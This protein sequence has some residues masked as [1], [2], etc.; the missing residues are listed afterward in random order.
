MA[1][2]S[3]AP[4]P[5]ATPPAAAPPAAAAPP[6][7]PI[8]IVN[9]DLSFARYPVVVGHFLGDSIAGAEAQLDFA[10]EA[11]LKKRYALGIYP[12]TVGTAMVVPPPHGSGTTGVVVGLGDIGA[13]SPGMIRGALI[14]GLLELALSSA[15]P[16]GASGVSLIQLGTRAGTVSITD[17]V[18]ASLA[19]LAE[20]QRRLAEQ[21]LQP[22]TE[23]DFIALFEDDAHKLWHTLRRFIDSPHYRDLFSLEREVSYAAGAQ[24]RLMRMEDPDVWRAIQV[25]SADTG[26]GDMGFRFVAVGEQARAD[27]FLVGANKSFVQEF[28][29]TA[30][31]RKLNAAPTRALF[32]LIWPAE[33]KQTSQDDRN[34]RLIL[35]EAAAALPFELMDDRA[36]PP[37]GAATDAAGPPAVRRGMLRQ[38]IQSRFARLQTSP[39]GGE[40]AL[41]IG[42]PR[43][44]AP[45]ADFAPLPGARA[46]AEMVADAL[47]AQ[48][49][50]VVRLIGDAV[51]P[52]EVV[53]QVLQGGWTILHVSAHG[54]Y[55]YPF[56]S[57]R[58]VA[59]AAGWDGDWTHYT[60]PRYTGVVLGDR[61]TLSP[62]IL[63][64][65]PDPPVLAFINC[66]SLASID[67][68][69]EA[70][71]RA[72]ARPEFAASFAA[73]L[74]ALGSRA[75]I[76]AGW[77]VSDQGALVFARSVYR[78]LLA[79]N[80]GFGEAVRVARGDVYDNDPDDATWGAYQ[81]YG[82]PDWRP[83]PDNEVR[84]KVLPAPCFAS[85]AEAIAEIDGIRN[86]AEVG[87]GRDSRRDGLIDRLRTIQEAIRDLGWLVRD[88]VREQLGHAYLALGERQEALQHF[89]EALKLDAGPTLRLVEALAN[90]RIR[91][92][93]ANAH[94]AGAAPPDAALGEIC[95]ARQQL[96]LLCQV[97]GTTAER[98]SLIGG[99]AQ[100]EALL[101]AAE[102]RDTA[103]AQMRDAY[104]QAWTLSRARGSSD[105]YYPGLMTVSAN[106][107]IAL[108]AGA[109]LAPCRAGLDDLD[110]DFA[111]EPVPGDYYRAV[112]LATRDLLVALVA[113]GT[114]E[115]EA[116]KLA[117]EFHAAW[118]ISGDATELDS[119]LSHLRLLATILSDH[120]STHAAAS[121]VDAIETAAAGTTAPATATTAQG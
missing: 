105:S 110:H 59:S 56:R 111:G 63:Q 41:V 38:L 83:R 32:Q 119:L 23:I 116:L 8:T 2:A 40:R 21:G 101:A 78:E 102:T 103:L 53:E 79:N 98:L 44:G 69:D 19:A 12:G 120:D 14:A 74:I 37:D 51:T 89:E 60:G 46:E 73:E 80:Q 22:F 34:L 100:R 9:G 99:A 104:G 27:G 92:A 96:V 76:A 15:R 114:T 117:G 86:Q 68:N 93:A 13:F 52:D 18:S 45:A 108:R 35:D 33:L 66:C 1:S 10:L 95:A 90:L 16:P 31:K 50:Q 115:E 42:D 4:T 97:A 17:T 64:S 3:P 39:R 87:A 71:L 85:P 6:Q 67:P 54:I 70:Q 77:E 94:A 118:E 7:T 62:S 11:S 20:A 28:V 112:S 113:G 57:D 91:Q 48:G 81:C 36:A 24:R 121:W 55:D 106:I 65:M 107:L 82:E 47:E 72:A 29:E 43:G 84:A 25:T 109:D 61:L 49:F 26:S 75:V 5:D 88:G 58:A 30:Q